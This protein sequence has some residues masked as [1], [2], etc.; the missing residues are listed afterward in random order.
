MS[1]ATESKVLDIKD[2]QFSLSI[3]VDQPNNNNNNGSTKLSRSCSVVKL[4]SI[5]MSLTDCGILLT[6]CN[7]T[8]KKGPL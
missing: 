5:T 3:L 6:S 1:S 4:K 2:T 8:T 7:K